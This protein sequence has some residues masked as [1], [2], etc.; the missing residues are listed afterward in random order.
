MN[1]IEKYII[2]PQTKEQRE[3]LAVVE[4]AKT[5]IGTPYHTNADVKGAGIDCGML[6]VRVYVDTGVIE[7]FD[8][9]PYPSQWAF[10]QKA[11]RYLAI[12]LRFGKE[13]PG[14]PLPGDL[15]MFKVG[16]CWAHGVIVIDWP[17]VIHANPPGVCDYHNIGKDFALSKREIRFFS[18]W[19]K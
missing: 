17:L 13:F 15:A 19:G 16:N 1:T 9:R 11:E 10:H 6:L 14:P 3:R 12:V 8:P 2:R 7:P 5:W 4:E 18:P